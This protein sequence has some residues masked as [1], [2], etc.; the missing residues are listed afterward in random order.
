S[1][2]FG[3]ALVPSGRLGDAHGR[4]WLFI[5]GVMLFCAS[6]IVA[7]TAQ[8]AWVVAAARLLQG[9]G[10]GTV[11][12]Q[13][14]GIIQ[15]LFDGRQ[16]TRALGAYAIVGGIAGVIGPLVGGTLIGALGDAYGW[17][18][19]LL[20]NVPFGLV[21]V[22]LAVRW[23]P[24]ARPAGRVRTSL[25]LPGLAGLAA[26]TLCLL[27]PFTLPG[28]QGPPRVVW[29]AAAPVL[30]V[31][32]IGW[33]RRYA[34]R[35][36]TP[37]LLP[38]LVGAGGFRT[39]T[40]IA[41]FQFGASLSSSLAITLY[42]QDRLGW[43]ALHAA[44]TTLPSALG[45]AVTSAFGWRVVGRYGAVSVAW[46]LVGSLVVVIATGCVLALVPSGHLG[47]ALTATQL[48]AG[49]ATGLIV[50]PNQALTLAHA[51][52]GSAGLAAGFLQLA[53][54]ISA[55]IGTAAVAGV[56]LS[57]PPGPGRAP[58]VHGLAVCA[59]ML[60]IATALAWRDALRDAHPPVPD[61]RNILVKHI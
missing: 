54:R 24:A 31:A 25:D 56:V 20:L 35:G 16:R 59:V 58:I 51:P 9:V 44:L 60:A 19:V 43:S 21:T 6:A 14:I 1:L 52:P 37:V 34:R 18:C 28:D 33:E 57:A 40:L 27:L 22:P 15:E 30:L 32:W 7:G 8:E 41:M 5:G 48:C 45:F 36:R 3:L 4:K 10:A 29:F 61:R 47:L 46:A 17:R 53:Q 39:G 55:S 13:V 50:S 42:L 11:N 38:S 26:V 49:A 23:F 12:P 2:T